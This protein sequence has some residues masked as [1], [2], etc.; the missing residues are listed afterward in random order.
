MPCSGRWTLSWADIS[1]C[2]TPLQSRDTFVTGVRQEVVEIVATRVRTL[3]RPARVGVD[4]VFLHNPDLRDLWDLTIFIAV[5]R[6]VAR[7][8]TRARRIAG[9]ERP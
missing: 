1:W 6:G 9:G 8:C 2:Q 5:D 4:G 3:P 7:T